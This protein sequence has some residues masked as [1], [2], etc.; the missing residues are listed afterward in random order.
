MIETKKIKL[1]FSVLEKQELQ[2]YLER[3]LKEGYV[4]TEVKGDFVYFSKQEE[5]NV[6]YIV[7]LFVPSNEWED[8]EESKK[9]QKQAFIEEYKTIGFELVGELYDYYIFRGEDGYL[10]NSD[11]KEIYG[12]I[13]Y[14][15]LKY[16]KDTVSG[17]LCAVLTWFILFSMSLSFGSIE[18]FFTA[19]I[20]WGYL[21]ATTL[22]SIL[23]CY[24]WISWIRY[25]RRMKRN[26]LKESSLEKSKIKR[27]IE[28]LL[29]IMIVMSVLGGAF[30]D[31]FNAEK[32]NGFILLGI[33]S[34]GL[35]G[36]ILSKVEEKKILRYL[37]TF[38][39]TISLIYLMF[40]VFTRLNISTYKE[41][42]EAFTYRQ[43][44]E[45]LPLV[46]LQQRE[47]ETKNLRIEMTYNQTLL[48]KAYYNY[49]EWQEFQGKENIYIETQFYEL[50][51]EFMTSLVLER[52]VKEEANRQYTKLTPEEL[53][54][55]NVD[56]GYKDIQ[57]RHIYLQKDE[58]I[59]KIQ[60]YNEILYD[61]IWCKRIRETVNKL[62]GSR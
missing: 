30:F 3:E 54:F 4:L 36:V 61:P 12:E 20:M 38:L 37:G 22:G 59:I 35:I 48:C 39:L 34:V 7:K 21:G 19:N 62:E 2:A 23:L 32:Q 18:S 49:N 53:Q 51:F 31:S 27:R 46:M 50:R 41:G 9:A 10:V 1:W 57:S 24:Y 5:E 11:D 8:T 28:K 25:K 55:Y 44:Y 40:M 47:N 6:Q 26:L 29:L 16:F 45:Q 15:R 56:S 13:N 33:G 43:Q 42:M 17:P 14:A 58:S 52:L 60:S